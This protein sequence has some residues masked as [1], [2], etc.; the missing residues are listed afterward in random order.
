MQLI[1]MLDSPYVRRVAIS[2]QLLELPW[3]HLPLSVFRNMPEFRQIN[4]VIKVP[5]L[6]CDDGELLM[7]SSLILD[8][9]ERLVPAE[10]RLLPEALPARQHA[11]HGVGLA[12]AAMEKAVQAYYECNLRPAEARHA[13]WLE[14]VAEQLNGACTLMENHL[15]RHAPQV[16]KLDQATLSIAVAWRFIAERA[17]E[18]VAADA[19]PAL[20]AWS[21]QAEA[22]PAFLAFPFD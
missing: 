5:T 18:H 9:L 1:G 20:R 8:Y 17:A 2:L 14:R 7:D 6:V 16:D 22:H 15:Q 4:P 10:R 11:L 3:Q 21:R 12:L 19:Y 13:P